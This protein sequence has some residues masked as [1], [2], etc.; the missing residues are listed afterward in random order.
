MIAFAMATSALVGLQSALAPAAHAAAGAA[1][2]PAEPAIFISTGAPTQLKIGRANA[3]GGTDY[4]DVGPVAPVQYNG[5]AYN[6][7][8]NYLYASVG[9]GG[10]AEYPQG[11]FI[12]IGAQGGIEL[13]GNPGSYFIVGDFGPGGNYYG[14]S[15]LEPNQMRVVNPANGQVIGTITLTQ[16]AIGNDFTYAYGYFWASSGTS[17]Q[18]IDPA[19]GASDVFAGPLPAGSYGAAWTYGN[20]ALGFGNNDTGELYQV[21]VTNPD[22]ANPTFAQVYSSSGTATTNNDGASSPGLPVDLGIVKTGPATVVAGQTVTWTLTVTNYGRGVSSRS[23]MTDTIPA[24]FTNVRAPDGGCTI[25]GSNVTC[26]GGRLGINETRTYTIQATATAD[27]TAAT[28][29]TA[30]IRGDEEDPNPSNDSSTVPIAPVGLSLVKSVAAVND[31]NGNGITDAGDTIRYAFAVTNTGAATVNGITINDARITGATCA[32]TSIAPGQVSNCTANSLYTINPGDVNNGQVVNTATASGTTDNG[33]PVTSY[34]SSTTTPTQAPAPGLSLVKSVSAQGDPLVAG[35]AVT[36]TFAVTNTGNVP[37]DGI[38]IN[39][40]SFSGTGELSAISCPAGRLAVN[41]QTECTASYTLTQ[42]DVDAGTVTN[43]ATSTGT[44]PGGPPVT[45]NEDDAN[46][47]V[48]PAPSLLLT[49]SADPQSVTAAGQGITYSFRVQNTGN[50]TVSALTIGEVAFSGTGELSAID[51]PVTTLAPGAITT[52]TADYVATQAD[53]DA[54]TITN[55][56]VATGNT[57]AGPPV[58]SNESDAVI[59]APRT[60]GLALVKEADV[61]QPKVG[62]TITYTFTLTNTGNVTITNPSISETEFSGTGDAPVIECAATTSLA[63]GESLVCTATY[64]VTQA[65]VDAGGVTNVATG[66]GEPP[67]GVDPPEDPS[68]SVEV[69]ITPAPGLSIV[70]T[71]SVDTVTQ[72]GQVVD[73]TFLITNTGN[74]TLTDIAVQEGSFS[75]AG[76]LSAVTCPAEAARLAPGDSVTCS[77][78]YRVVLADLNSGELSNTASA[79]GTPPSGPPTGSNDSTVNIP[80]ISPTGNLPPTGVELPAMLPWIA[81]ALLLIGAA[82]VTV[83]VRRKNKAADAEL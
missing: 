1:F 62:D 79:I 14:T 15:F 70:K 57:P 67:T 76:Q 63:P 64:V 7:A 42:A 66:T 40:T 56:A 55:T 26:L 29:N 12:R 47:T 73:Y 18:R 32:P 77:A 45:S 82:T 33:T 78:T 59:D 71:A 49:K 68:S 31:V 39:E 2:D 34:E 58:S 41:A 10:T 21:Q 44:P 28:S 36:Y 6:T 75:G 35:S 20:G 17:I 65:D 27:L 53:I 22:S 8:D 48:P 19:T 13:V 50:V 23:L 37:L 80:A 5:L 3:N 9:G 46:L 81:L 51:C 11:S 69:P 74:V 16:A 4:E 60:P 25:I 38:V 52:C 54:G 24:G 43:A 83:T 61:T 30:N 72:V